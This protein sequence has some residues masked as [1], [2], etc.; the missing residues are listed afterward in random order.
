MQRIKRPLTLGLIIGLIFLTLVAVLFLPR[1]GRERPV[2]AELLIRDGEWHIGDRIPI[3]L[4]VVAERGFRFEAPDL[5]LTGV[6][7]HSE[8]LEFIKEGEIYKESWWDHRYEGRYTFATFQPGEYHLP[9]MTIQYTTP[10]GEHKNIQLPATTL[11]VTSLLTDDAKEIRG[12]KPLAKA[13]VNPLL[14]YGLA[15]IALLGLVVWFVIRRLRKRA[16]EAE[17]EVVSSL[18]AHAMAYRRLHQLLVSDWIEKGQVERYFTI[19]SE[20][21]R[22]YIEHRFG[23]RAREM[24]TQEFLSQSL[25]RLGLAS[26]QQETLRRFMELSDLVKYAKHVPAYEEIREAYDVARRFVDETKEEPGEP[27]EER[28]EIHAKPGF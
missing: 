17:V 6:E 7:E 12:L 5:K 2:D 3:T 14:Y 27:E 9:A 4:R 23:A 16:P 19:L 11:T 18:S 22:E 21:I 15:L 25:R 1:A 8:E 13:T 20:I 28:G 10:A 24:T 26:E